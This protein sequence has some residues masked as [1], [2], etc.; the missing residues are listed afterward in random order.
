MNERQKA[1]ADKIVDYLCQTLR[2]PKENVNYDVPLFGDGIGLDSVDS[3]EI[4][5]GMNLLFGVSLMGVN[6]GVFANIR[7]LSE[8]IINDPDYKE[9]QSNG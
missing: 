4:I 1:V 6:D 2:L 9:N 3:L 7:T 8:Y 5:A